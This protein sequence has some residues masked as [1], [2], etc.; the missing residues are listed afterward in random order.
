MLAG[1][2]VATVENSSVSRPS[3]VGIESVR[4]GNILFSQV[5]GLVAWFK[6]V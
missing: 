4:K 6:M 1:H 3:L 5:T 2:G